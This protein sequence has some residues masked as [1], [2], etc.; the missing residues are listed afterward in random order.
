L[1][2][3]GAILM[4]MTAVGLL[5]R[6]PKWAKKLPPERRMSFIPEAVV[7]NDES[8]FSAP[9]TDTSENDHKQSSLKVIA[10]QVTEVFKSIMFYVLLISWLVLCY[11][12]DIFFSTIIDFA[13]D[14]GVL[15]SDAMSLIPY[16]SI[17]DLIGRIVLPLLADRKYVRRSTLSL[18]NFLFLGTGMA[19]LPLV[20]S[21]ASLL[22]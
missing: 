5:F 9:Q 7:Y 10:H 4:N 6:E 2:L 19:V 13:I 18:L 21:Y 17:T 16:F 11:D 12:F 15:L 8:E 14:T 22:A 3:L 20:T 1:L